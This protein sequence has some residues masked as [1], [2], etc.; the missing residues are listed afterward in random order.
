[1]GWWPHRKLPREKLSILLRELQS[2][3]EELPDHLDEVREAKQRVATTAARFEDEE[4]GAGSVPVA[5]QL[6]DWLIWY[7]RLVFFFLQLR[8]YFHE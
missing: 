1:V 3:F 4:E 5:Y 7:L 2:F 8:H 6:G